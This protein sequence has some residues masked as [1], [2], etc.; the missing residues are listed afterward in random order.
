MGSVW[1]VGKW[2]RGGRGEGR[3]VVTRKRGGEG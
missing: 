1:H 2:R 3:G